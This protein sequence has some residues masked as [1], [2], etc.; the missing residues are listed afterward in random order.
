MDDIISYQLI[1]YRCGYLDIGLQPVGC[2]AVCASREAIAK[3][4]IA[5][6]N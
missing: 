6:T 4:A 5:A 1:G 2:G 3:S